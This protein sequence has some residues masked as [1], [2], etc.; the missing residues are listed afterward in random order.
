MRL[1]LQ[2]LGRGDCSESPGEGQSNYNSKEAELLY[3]VWSQK[4]G[5]RR[6]VGT[7]LSAL[8]LEEEPRPKG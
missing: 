8:G 1:K 6:M 4:C 3:W 2:N 5:N 7:M